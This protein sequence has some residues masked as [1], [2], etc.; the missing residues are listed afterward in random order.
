M[1]M[2]TEDNNGDDD[3]LWLQQWLLIRQFPHPAH[4]ADKDY[5]A[6][7]RQIS[8][9]AQSVTARNTL[10]NHNAADGDHNDENKDGHCAK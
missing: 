4:L 1:A 7:Y 5:R 10:L 3:R 2:M 9:N 6:T 8:S